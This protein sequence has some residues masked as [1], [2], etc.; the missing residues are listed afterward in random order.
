[1]EPYYAVF[2]GIMRSIYSNRLQWVFLSATMEPPNRVEFDRSENMLS[3]GRFGEPLPRTAPHCSPKGLN[4]NVLV[5][6]VPQWYIP[7]DGN[8]LRSRG[9]RFDN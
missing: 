4:G 8:V 3:T 9:V 6:D 2:T 7:N 1:M 5:I